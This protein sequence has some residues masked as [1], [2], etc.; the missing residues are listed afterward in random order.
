MSIIKKSIEI[1]DA[2]I[3]FVSL[4]DRPANRRSFLLTKSEDKPDDAT[5]EVNGRFISK[6]SNS[7]EA[8]YVTGVA[9]E[10]MVADTDDNFMTA[11]EIEKMAH[12]FMKNGRMVDEQH[13][14]DPNTKC[15][16]VESWIANDDTE[17]G[18]QPVQK[19]T[20]LVKVEVRDDEVWKKIENNEIGGFSIGG[21]AKYGT[22][23]VN[24]TD[25]AE[26]AEKGAKTVDTRDEATTKNEKRGLLAALAKYLGVED[27]QKGVVR[28]QY[29]RENK[30]QG[31]WRAARILEQVL[32]PYS[33]Y[34]EQRE[35]EGDPQKVMEALKDFAEIVTELLLED[36]V[37]I[38]KALAVDA[39]ES[40]ENG[41]VSVEKAGRK[42]S[43]ARLN[44]L[45][46][47]QSAVNQLIA[48]ADD[49]K[50]EEEDDSDEDDQADGS[51][52]NANDNADNNDTE[53]TD[54]AK[55]TKKSELKEEEN[56]SHDEIVLLAQEIAK[57]MKPAAD[58]AV[59]KNDTPA[60]APDAAPETITKDEAQA[61]IAD[62]VAK[63]LN[64]S[65]AT[66]ESARE[67]MELTK[68]EVQKMIDEAV[69]EVKKAR[70]IPA[71]LNDTTQSEKVEK[72]GDIWAGFIL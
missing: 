63:A 39:E 54:D 22:E 8:H 40:V 46:E 71:N 1:Y 36:P 60:V 17:I 16:I 44:K 56:M 7:D 47:I 32:M 72:N 18:G 65:E 14:F 57:A 38:T 42:M 37:E 51:N 26:G 34:T 55:E 11:E 5:F 66:E 4:V 64:E 58:A 43:A 20:W 61:M 69:S 49:P 33:P 3:S 19:G 50:D 15:A 25:T 12:W 70:G 23:D 29:D 24:I 31:F 62:A 30:A 10:P 6:E 59:E 67:K 21:V 9:Y 2:K 28:D 52:N 27:V 35:P 48:E 41:T 53:D 13:S 45:K 68:S